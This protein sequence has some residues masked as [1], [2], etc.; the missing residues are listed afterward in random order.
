LCSARNFYACGFRIDEPLH[1]SI[2]LTVSVNDL[3][4]QTFHLK[5]GRAI[6][7]GIIDPV[8]LQGISN[9]SL[10][11]G[12]GRRRRSSGAHRPEQL[13]Y[14]GEQRIDRCCTMYL[15]N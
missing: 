15:S 7:V 6:N 2:A 3:L 1:G 4:T 12:C 11:P 14:F 9:R 8:L 5:T 13:R 10:G